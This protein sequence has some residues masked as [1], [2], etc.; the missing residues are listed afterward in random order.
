MH[1]RLT[2]L[3]AAAFA[4]VFLSTLSANVSADNHIVTENLNPGTTSWRLVNPANDSTS[5]IK[6]YVDRTSV[7]VGETIRFHVSVNPAQQYS[8]RVYRMGYYAGLGGRELWAR[9]V[10]NGTRQNICPLDS[11]TGQITCSWSSD[12][13]LT[14]PGNWVTGIYLAKVT[15]SAGFDNHIPFVVRH[16]GGIPDLL[17]Q[18][19]VTTYH[20]YNNYPD[21]GVTGKSTYDYNSHGANTLVG[22]KRAMRVSFD[23]PLENTGSYLYFLYE[24]ELVMFLEERGYDVGYVNDID[25]HAAPAVLNGIKGFISAGHDEYWTWEMR[26][27]VDAARDSGTDLAFF[28]A[29]AV[30]WQI[31]L[32]PGANGQANRVMEVYKDYSLDPEPNPVRKTVTFRSIGRAEQQLIGVQYIDYVDAGISA[33]FIARNTDH[34]IYEGTGVSNGYQ[35]PRIIGGEMDKLFS[36]YPGPV[37]TEYTVLGRSP[38]QGATQGVVNAETVIYRAPSG[39]WVFGSGTLLW[40]H[41]LN[42][43]GTRSTVLRRMTSNLLDRYVDAQPGGTPTLEVSATSVVEDS[44]TLNIDVSLSNASAVPVSFKLATIGA[45][46]TPGQD[47]YGR[48]QAVTLAPGVTSFQWPVTVVDDLVPEST[49]SFIVRVFGVQAAT[50]TTTTV[51]ASIVDNDQA[52]PPTLSIANQVV[53]EP[54][55]SVEFTVSLSAPSAQNVSVGFSTTNGGTAVKGVDYYG[56]FEVL[57]IPAGQTTVTKSVFV[58][59]DSTVEPLETIRV[60]IFNPQNATVANRFATATIQSDD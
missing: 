12:V 14:I 21:D 57:Q 42:K 36:Q 6:G 27:A 29:N 51:T 11:S 5:Q 24:H 55:G 8:I 22:S 28:G 53:N 50:A 59:D 32:K 46:A 52:G 45:T 48:Y 20:A 60:Q 43:P 39:A 16:S 7:S 17:Y 38:I 44:G 3:A 33:S 19:P 56:T 31:R 13:A 49:E 37:S 40:H 9:T 23:R 4:W 41:G 47:F 1:T 10:T 35:I 25:T 26:N 58:I 18:Q 54:D 2:G 30:F 15:N 34:W